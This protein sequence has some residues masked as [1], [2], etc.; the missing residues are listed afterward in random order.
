M[1]CD[2]G[3][4]GN[5]FHVLSYDTILIYVLFIF[6]FTIKIVTPSLADVQM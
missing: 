2:S 4:I 1:I 5:V 6:T 3:N